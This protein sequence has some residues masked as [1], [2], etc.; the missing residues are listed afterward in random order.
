[1]ATH[2]L[3]VSLR[4]CLMLVP[5]DPDNFRWHGL[6]LIYPSGKNDGRWVV[7]S[8]ALEI[9]VVDLTAVKVRTLH[10]NQPLPLEIIHET[11]FFDHVDDD[12]IDRLLREAKSYASMIGFA[13]P[14]PAE[15][16]DELG[17]WRVADVTHQSF[18][19]L[20]PDDALDE[21]DLVSIKEDGTGRAV[22]LV[23]ID[24]SWVYME[25]V[26]DDNVSGWKRRIGASG[27]GDPR[28][29]DQKTRNGEP[30]RREE[31]SLELCCLDKPDHHAALFNGPP[32]GP[33]HAGSLTAIGHT[34]LMH[35]SEFV[36]KSGIPEKGGIAREHESLT[37]AIRLAL[38]VDQRDIFQNASDEHTLRRMVMLEMA[39]SRDPKN[40]DW[41]GLD[42]LTTRKVTASGSVDLPK[43]SQWLASAQKDR[44][45]VLK[46]GRL[47][48]EEEEAKKKK[49]KTPPN[50][51]KGKG[52]K[53]GEEA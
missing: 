5:D 38:V 28:V 4:Q 13:A 45:T 10:R 43:V 20:V 23:L 44:M 50:G 36:Q 3:D 52:A 6:L 39:V 22:G 2:S 25:R 29:H 40:P 37:E 42:L 17:R 27:R 48:R 35:H 11:F 47:L 26:H 9:S 41:E 34:F 32:V 46:Q 16:S 1:M 14:G 51:P 53:G 18:G 8:P 31:D 15:A 33:E 30:Y 19:E 21:Q 24:D 49:P 12:L 7:A